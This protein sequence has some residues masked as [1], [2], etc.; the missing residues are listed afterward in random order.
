MK[1]NLA[2]PKEWFNFSTYQ[3]FKIGLIINFIG[4]CSLSLPVLGYEELDITRNNVIGYL[5]ISHILTIILA[6][7]HGYSK[8]PSVFGA[9]TTVFGFIP[10]LGW[11]M[12]LITAILTGPLSVRLVIACPYSKRHRPINDRIKARENKKR[13]HGEKKPYSSKK[14]DF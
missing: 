3:I 14:I 11:I 9:F 8:T 1:T 2:T 4:H 6:Q 10:Y 5:F 12:H 13:K 7:Y